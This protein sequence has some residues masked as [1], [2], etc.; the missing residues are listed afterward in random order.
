MQGIQKVNMRVR[1]NQN[2]VQA[3]P[4]TILAVDDD[5]SQRCL[6]QRTFSGLSHN[7]K[8]QLLCSGNEA[9]A[10]LEGAGK[11]GDRKKYPLP[12]WIIT[13]L[14]MADGDGRALLEFVKKNPALSAIPVA[15]LSS[16]DNAED[17]RQCRLLGC[18]AYYVKP[19]TPTQLH[20]LLQTTVQSPRVRHA[21]RVKQRSSHW[22]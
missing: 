6:M 8:L 12:V 17:I 18:S 1:R 15:V 3:D 19:F 11:F 13:D 21:A 22:T 2:F 7:Y 20:E 14:H 9:I 5:E 10:Y 16:S 4:P